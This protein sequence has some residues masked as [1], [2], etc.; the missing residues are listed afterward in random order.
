M[1]DRGERGIGHAPLGQRHEGWLLTF[2][3]SVCRARASGTVL[4]G[5]ETRIATNARCGNS[6]SLS[7]IVRAA[8]RYAVWYDLAFAFNGIGRTFADPRVGRGDRIAVLRSS[9]RA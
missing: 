7:R 2:E 5:I 9:G 3:K 6:S 8:R 1:S 4:A